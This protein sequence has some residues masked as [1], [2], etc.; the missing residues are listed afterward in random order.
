MDPIYLRPPPRLRRRVAHAAAHTDQP[1][2]C[3]CRFLIGLWQAAGEP[4]LPP[5]EE[6]DNSRR[7]VKI[8]VPRAMAVALRVG[9]ARSNTRLSA[10]VCRILHAY[11]PFTIETLNDA[12]INGE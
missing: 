3:Y 7:Q 11:A 9:A 1:F 12:I 6:E 4:E 5:V 2:S 10:L 8:P